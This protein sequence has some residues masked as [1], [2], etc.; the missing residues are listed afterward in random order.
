MKITCKLTPNSLDFIRK[1]ES[2]PRNLTTALAQ[3]TDDAG[4]LLTDGSK[5]TIDMQDFA[6][7]KDWWLEFKTSH[8][9][10]GGIL[11][12]VGLIQS[13]ITYKRLTTS[14]AFVM[15]HVGYLDGASH[16]CIGYKNNGAPHGSVST[17]QL[18]KWQGTGSYGGPSRAF[19]ST[20]AKRLEQQV[21]ALY[22]AVA[23]TAMGSV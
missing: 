5:Q 2:F 1:L 6:G 21:Y 7:I 4:K 17:W 23:A 14:S 10:S 11:K 20:T 12:M 16:P 3:A 13:Q 15:G 8:G 22:S 18:V 19:F 9:F